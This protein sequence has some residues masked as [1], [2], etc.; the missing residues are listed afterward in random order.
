MTRSVAPAALPRDFHRRW[1]TL[2]PPLRPTAEI[3]AQIAAELGHGGDPVLL[4]G[5]TPELAA[6]DRPMIALDWSP[7][8]IALA[9][10]GDTKLRHVHVGD[11]KA[12]PLGD[13]S[14]GGAMG[15]GAVTMLAWPGEA[16]QLFAEL[17]RVVRCGGRI[18]LRCFATAEQ[19]EAVGD[20]CVEALAGTLGFHAFKLRFN[21]ACARELGGLCVPSAALFARFQAMFPDRA[22]LSAAS[23]W[24]AAAIAE[25]DAYDGSTYLHAYPKRSELA[26][27]L[28]AHWPGPWRFVETQ[29][30]PLAQLCPLL[31]LDRP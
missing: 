23:G 11:W 9:W 8:M 16:Q 20:V 21:M 5:V 28:S 29:G 18:A 14:V 19:A 4:L 17:W 31:V 10:P 2:K 26:A 27:L 7:A 1:P 6:I 12:M 15:D 25:F 24:S 13:A 30:Y 22:A 3:A